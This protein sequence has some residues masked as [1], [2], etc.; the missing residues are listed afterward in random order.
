MK[1]VLTKALALSISLLILGVVL[2][3]AAC[4]DDVATTTSGGPS[5]TTVPSTTT[6]LA[7]DPSTF[8]VTFTNEY[9]AATLGMMYLYERNLEDGTRA[10]VTLA[11]TSETRVVMGVECAVFTGYVYMDD[12]T[13]RSHT[14]TVAWYAEDAGG[15]VW[16]F[17]EEITN[18]EGEE[19]VDAVSWE[20]GVNGAVPAMVMEG[21]PKPGDLYH[22]GY[23]G[24]L[25]EIMAE[26]LD[27]NSTVEIPYGSFEQVVKVREWTPSR[28]GAT[29]VKY[30]APGVGLV[31]VEQGESGLVID[32]LVNLYSP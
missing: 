32:R 27:V 10:R 11:P 16:C 22:Q 21:E 20:A 4:S 29:K 30:Y 2:T 24:G 19:A 14:D 25:V 3:V 23:A 7:I 8:S 26:V 13:V 31:L 15:N 9:F 18:Y 28:P 12:P 17:G 5:T 1:H 6:T